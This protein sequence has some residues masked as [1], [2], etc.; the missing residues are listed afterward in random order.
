VLGQPQQ[1]RFLLP[2]PAARVAGQ[3][4]LAGASGDRRCGS[5]GQVGGDRGA[6]QPLRVANAQ[7]AV[8]VGLPAAPPWRLHQAELDGPQAQRRGRA[9]QA[10]PEP[11]QVVAA[12][13]PDAHATAAWHE[14][15]H[16]VAGRRRWPGP[17]PT[18]RR[19]N[20]LLDQLAQ[21]Q[22]PRPRRRG[23]AAEGG[24]GSGASR[25][26]GP[27]PDSTLLPDL[28][29]LCAW[30][31]APTSA[32]TRTDLTDLTRLSLQPSAWGSGPR[33]PAGLCVRRLVPVSA[34]AEDRAAWSVAVAGARGA[35][36]SS[37]ACRRRGR[38]DWRGR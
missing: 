7:P 20:V 9:P 13:R 38:A 37:A 19:G 33:V 1:L 31:A 10:P 4:E 26:A 29:S 15:H 34:R 28:A 22:A 27:R 2:G 16:L 14:R 11:G 17:A 5:A 35:P 25:E 12:P 8:F 6:G 21:Q 3:A 32:I 36:A 23:T 30:P 24:P 18:R